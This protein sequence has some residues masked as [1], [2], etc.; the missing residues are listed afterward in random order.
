MSSF[1]HIKKASAL[2]ILIAFSPKLV[3]AQPVNNFEGLVGKIY[4][5]LSSIVPLIVALTLI[6]FLWGIFQLVRSNSEDARADA[7]KVITFGVIALF[8]MVSVWGLVA[9]LSNTFFG[10]SQLFIPQLR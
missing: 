4:G 5:M 3:L 2:L 1:S 9:I 6:V 8:V 7:I 10:G